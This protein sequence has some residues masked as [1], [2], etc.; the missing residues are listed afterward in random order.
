MPKKTPETLPEVAAA[1]AQLDALPSEWVSDR[2]REQVL[3]RAHQQALANSIDRR[4]A[5]ASAEVVAALARG[6]VDRALVAEARGHA[7]G[8]LRGKVPGLTLDLNLAREVLGVAGSR[9]TATVRVIELAELAYEYER[10]QWRSYCQSTGKILDAPQASDLDRAAIPVRA[11]AVKIR[12]GIVATQQ[13]WV[14]DV[15]T[16]TADPLQLLTS[17]KSQID[18]A[19]PVA[20][21]IAAA[22]GVIVR[23]NAYRR[24]S[25][26]TWNYDRALAAER[27]QMA[28]V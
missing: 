27:L 15:S 3:A 10:R 19:G 8:A 13:A 18:A 24:E 11:E 5:E 16:S 20:E 25:G 7:L 9:L 21:K 14:R 2:F 4:L 17:A 28:G 6:E 23:A 26:L 12:E 22:N 1:Q